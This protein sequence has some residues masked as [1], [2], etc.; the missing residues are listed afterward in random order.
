[1]AMVRQLNLRGNMII[2]DHGGGLFSGYAHLSSFAVAEGQTVAAG[3]VIG[4]VGNTGLST[5]SHL[6]WEMSVGGILV[7]G[8]RFAD[9]S[10]GF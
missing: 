5:G 6:H 1:V 10:D 2:I 9:G 7:D 4:A 3:D 8:L